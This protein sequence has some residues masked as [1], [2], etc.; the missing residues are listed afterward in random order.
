MPTV[1]VTGCGGA[2]GQGVIKA[3]RLGS[4]KWRLIGSDSDRYAAVF[5]MKNTALRKTHL[6]PESSDPNYIPE[7]TGLCRKE[8]VDVIFPCTDAELE[9]LAYARRDLMDRGT[10][11]VISPQETIRICKDKWL[12]YQHLGKFLPIVK[13]ALPEMGTGKAV[14]FTGLPA[15]IKPRIGWGSKQ[16]FKL[17]SVKEAQI[18]MKEIDKPIIQ[19]CLEGEEYTVDC[20]VDRSGT[21]ISVVPRRRIKIFSGL[22]FEGITVKDQKLI[23]LGHKIIKYIHIYGPFNFQAKEI[24]GEPIIFEINPRF[25]GTGILAVKAGANIPFLAVREICGM[26]IPTNVCF[27]DGVFLSRYFDETIFKFSEANYREN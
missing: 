23:E 10:K 5:H 12:T 21:A 11:I 17:R 4:R 13:S 14:Q 26:K 19:T 18:L 2:I 20:L 1:L 3:L 6:L 8:K 24:E 25:S 22:S 15:V 27:E 9:K 7:I 16:T